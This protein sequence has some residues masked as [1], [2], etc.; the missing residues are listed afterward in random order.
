MMPR[1]FRALVAIAALAGCSSAG[2]DGN[3]KCTNSCHCQGSDST[4]SAGALLGA[5]SSVAASAAPSSVATASKLGGQ[6]SDSS[7][8]APQPASLLDCN[9]CTLKSAYYYAVPDDSPKD[10]HRLDVTPNIRALW[11]MHHRI[12]TG[13]NELFGDPCRNFTKRLTI[14]TTYNRAVGITQIYKLTELEGVA[15]NFKGCC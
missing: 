14:E 12:F 5:P 4:S 8:A 9:H 13:S 1:C 11:N 6:A 2:S 10:C 7:G 15:M 3:A